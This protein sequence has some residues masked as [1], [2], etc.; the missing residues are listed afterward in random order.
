MKRAPSFLRRLSVF[1]LCAAL[2]LAAIHSSSFA[3][4]SRCAE[5]SLAGDAMPD[6]G[7]DAPAAVECALQCALAPAGGAID[8]SLAA[9]SPKL[10]LAAHAAWPQPRYVS[11][12]GP[13]P[14]Q[15]P[16]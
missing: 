14:F 7:C 4:E 16:R 10:T 15:P 6:C 11:Y 2:G 12:L 13:A 8:S 9:F 3:A 1:I 5:A